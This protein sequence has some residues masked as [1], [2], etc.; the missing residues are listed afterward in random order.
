MNLNS[1]VIM[2]SGKLNLTIVRHDSATLAAV[3]ALNLPRLREQLSKA[4]AGIKAKLK[5]ADAE[6]KTL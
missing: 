4:I 6:F 5:A 1:S 3:R 2:L